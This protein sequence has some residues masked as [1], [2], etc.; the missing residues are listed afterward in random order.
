[1]AQRKTVQRGPRTPPASYRLMNWLLDRVLA[2]A[3][4]VLCPF[5]IVTGAWRVVS[6]LVWT[7][8]NEYAKRSFGHC[9]EG[10]RIH[11]PFFVTAPEKLFVGDNVH[12]NANAFLRAEGGL[13]I[14][15]NTHIS[16]NLTVY[17]MNHAYEGRCL[18]YDSD[19]ILKSVRIGRNAWIGMNVS[20]VPGVTIG[21]GAIIGMGTSV[22][23]D[24]P[25]LGVVGSAPQR[26]VK[27]RDEDHYEA[28]DAGRRYG[29][30]SGYPLGD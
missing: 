27:M 22:A 2:R 23:Q 28:S 20:V 14:G 11:G 15:D 19:R 26:V 29:G 25:P 16:R 10:V 7:L 12:I 24:V 8:S 17:T 30:M 1:M 9:G 21:D 6:R 18:P 4:I 13:H 5:R 3:R